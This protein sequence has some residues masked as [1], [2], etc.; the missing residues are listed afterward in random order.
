M[1]HEAE[2]RE[3]AVVAASGR[4][5]ITAVIIIFELTGNYR[6]ILPLMC[7]VVVAAAPSTA[8]TK[9]TIYTLKLRRRGI[10]IDAPT[11]PSRLARI[12]IGDAMGRTPAPLEP[13]Q[14]L[15]ALVRHFAAE[16]TESLPVIAP[17]GVLLGI[18]AADDVE[19]A[20]GAL[21]ATEREGVPG[22]RRSGACD[23]V[24]HPPPRAY[25]GRNGTPV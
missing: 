3:G 2:A 22:R 16:R 19:E 24:N 8:V 7:A 14:P 15:G 18:A 4:A 21:G 1:R 10:D 11:A 23:R 13:E 5:P 20:V 17:D 9:D 6:I 25:L 12:Q